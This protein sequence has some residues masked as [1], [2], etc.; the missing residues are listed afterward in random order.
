MKN[1]FTLLLLIIGVMLSSCQESEVPSPPVEVEFQLTN[2]DGKA[3]TIFEEG[4][5]ILFD[6]KI[7]NLKDE[8]VTWYFDSVFSYHNMFTV[9]KVENPSPERPG[10]EVVKI[11][12][13]Q[14]S[15]IERDFRLGRIIPAN[16]EMR[17][18]MSWTGNRENT[19]MF[20]NWSIYYYDRESLSPGKYFVEFEQGI[21]FAQYEAFYRK[22]RIDFEVR[23]K[24][25]NI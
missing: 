2:S 7:I 11:G 21:T 24:R 19:Y 15:Q 3:T 1:V 13:P 25:L 12:T 22:F 5:D 20:D 6:Y 17:I 8:T 10:G 23:K 4:E 18:L 14:T 9:Y 16:G